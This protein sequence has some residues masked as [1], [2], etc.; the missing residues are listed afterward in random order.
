MLSPRVKVPLYALQCC[1]LRCFAVQYLLLLLKCVDCCVTPSAA[2][3]CSAV[4]FAAVKVRGLL[5]HIICCDVVQCHV[6]D[7]CAVRWLAVSHHLLQLLPASSLCLNQKPGA[8]CFPLLSSL[9][10]LSDL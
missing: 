2:M 9:A 6:L 10:D 8:P 5:C 7:G 3:L 4:A 1:I